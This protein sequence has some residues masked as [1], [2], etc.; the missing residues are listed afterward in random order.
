[1]AEPHDPPRD[2]P[3]PEDDIQVSAEDMD[4]VAYLD[5]EL[6]RDSA[7][8]VEARL[9]LDPTA[10]TRAEELK[11][12]Y[13]LLEYLPKPEPSANFTERTLTR[14]ELPV[15][16][17]PATATVPTG[18]SPVQV[19]HTGWYV[20]P[21]WF[22]LLAAM[23][24]LGYASR[25]L[26]EDQ[27]TSADDLAF[28][29]IRV[30]EHLPL[31][32]GVDD[33]AFLK[34]LEES[35]L[36]PDDQAREHSEQRTL[37][38]EPV[39]PEQRDALTR[40]FRSYPPAR[41]QQLRQLDQQIHELPPPERVRFLQLL[42]E[43]AVWL[44]RL[45][46][47]D[48]HEVLSAP[49]GTERLDTIRRVKLRNWRM[50]LPVPVQQ[51]LDAIQDGDELA[52]TMAEYRQQ[53]RDRE[54]GWILAARQW[55]KL[56][57]E[58]HPWPFT[59]PELRKTVDDFAVQM[60]RPRLSTVEVAGFDWLRSHLGNEQSSE[61]KG[62]E[63]LMYGAL[64]YDYSFVRPCLPE[65]VNGQTVVTREDQLPTAF[66]RELNAA[67]RKRDVPRRPLQNL[68]TGRWPDYAEAVVREARE[69]GV[70]VRFP[71]GPSRLQEMPEPVARFITG[72]LKPKMRA[73][74]W[75]TLERFEGQWPDYPRRVYALARKHDLTIPG[76]MPP[77]SMQL[78]Q[79]YYGPVERRRPAP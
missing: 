40:V 59:D 79:H 3:P 54:T 63:W 36:F 68:P 51:R 25:M 12:T 29:D 48:R 77:G 73:E 6:D 61:P 2:L 33:F 70:P 16:S 24:S 65:Y 55:D 27:F 5:G 56:R 19:A 58:A 44:D 72:E 26:L 37:A 74:E 39:S 23:L 78:W 34:R 30:I 9:A 21:L 13:D 1:M 22:V 10:R 20:V 7:K 15:P 71:M 43:Y 11:K 4:L 53:D 31:Y 45:T 47:A 32:L 57:T 69:Y 76:L 14:I 62:I 52:R 64:I 66:V 41:Q 67:A 17:T 49:A 42:E 50:R 38:S 46:D 35:D 75:Q 60:I 8:D 28:T 18:S